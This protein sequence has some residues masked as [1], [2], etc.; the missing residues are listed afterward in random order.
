MPP[1]LIQVNAI[2]SKRCSFT[3]ARPGEQQEH[4]K[5]DARKRIPIVSK[6]A[7]TLERSPYHAHS[8]IWDATCPWL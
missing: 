8:G 2:P 5:I 7:H 3:Y 6:F 1:P 4:D